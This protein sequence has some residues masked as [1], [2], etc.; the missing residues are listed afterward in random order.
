LEF[1]TA[2]LSYQIDFA[3]RMIAKPGSRDYS[4][5]SVNVYYRAKA[6]IL[7]RIP[8]NAFFP[9]PSVESV[10]VRLEHRDPPFVVDDESFFSRI[11]REIFSHRNQLL[12]KVLKRFLRAYGLT[13]I[14]ATQI[15]KDAKVEDKRIVNIEPE[16]IARLSNTLGQSINK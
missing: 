7:E 12:R 5:L 16:S 1:R 9:M 4:R 14:D 10:I 11:L 8:R 13:S 3:K 6:Q 2:I 15:L